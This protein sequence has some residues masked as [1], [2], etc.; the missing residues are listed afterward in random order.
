MNQAHS[1]LVVNHLPIIFPMV[2][3][4]VLVG[5][6]IFRSAVIKRVAYFIFILGAVATL[7]TMLTGEGAEEVAEH[8]AGVSE[9]FIHEHEEKAELFAMLSYIVGVLSLIAL[10][11]N[12]KQNKLASLFSY[13]VLIVALG[14]LFMGKQTGT[15]GGEIRH[16]EIRTGKNATNGSMSEEAESD[17]D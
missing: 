1:H 15:S 13:G 3:L 2:G 17:D 8:I 9:R 7:P 6:F 16:T 5:G 14:A 4:I 10:W 11:L 12:W